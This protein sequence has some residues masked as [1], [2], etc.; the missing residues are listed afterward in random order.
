MIPAVFQVTFAAIITGVVALLFEHPWTA[1]PDTQAIFSILWLGI[2]G[3][4]IAY[5]VRVPPVRP[6][7][8]DPHDARRLRHP[9]G[10]H[11]ARVPRPRR[12]GRRA[13]RLRDRRWSSPASGSSTAGSGGGG[14]SGGCRRSRPSRPHR[15][16]GLG[17]TRARRRRRLRRHPLRRRPRAAAPRRRSAPTRRSAA[18]PRA[19]RR[20]RP[21]GPT[22]QAAAKTV[23]DSR[24]GATPDSGATLSATRMHRYAAERQ[25]SRRRPHAAFRRGPSRRRSAAGD[26][27][28]PDDEHDRARSPT[29]SRRT[30]PAS[31]RRVPTPVDGAVGRDHHAGREREQ[32]RRCPAPT[33]AAPAGAAGGPPRAPATA[34]GATRNPAIRHDDADR[35]GDAQPLAEERRRR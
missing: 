29:G 4:G 27:R 18:R 1:T 21:S 35:P 2:L 10:R 22:P 7:G 17:A 30:G 13:D 8:R 34:A 16:A 28:D 26:D 20:P 3:S 23:A 32:D 9:G 15:P 11:R 31:M 33:G 12:A 19:G 14:S 25:H 24:S 5:L 6:L